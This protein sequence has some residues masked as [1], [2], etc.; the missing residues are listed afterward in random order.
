MELF[1]ES[2][3]EDSNQEEK[4]DG[5]GHQHAS[6]KKVLKFHKTERRK[7]VKC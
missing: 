2:K 4:N 5:Y 7:F 3:K 6:H 1:N